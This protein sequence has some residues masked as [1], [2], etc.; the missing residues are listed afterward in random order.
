MYD[1]CT[2]RVIKIHN[3]NDNILVHQQQIQCYLIFLYTTLIFD[4]NFD[5]ITPP[6]IHCSAGVGRTG[7]FITVLRIM[8]RYFENIEKLPRKQGL[9]YDNSKESKEVEELLESIEV[10]YESSHEMVA[11]IILSLRTER[12]GMVQNQGQLDL[13]YDLLQE[14]FVDEIPKYLELEGTYHEKLMLMTSEKVQ[15]KLRTLYLLYNE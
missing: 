4:G 6:V 9:L 12:C 13:V 8:Q 3:T 7:T 11:K 10:N 2:M 1:S 5:S 14:F 15:P